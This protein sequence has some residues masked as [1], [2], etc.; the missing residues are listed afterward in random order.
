MTT[1]IA[2]FNVLRHPFQLIERAIPLVMTPLALQTMGISAIALSKRLHKGVVTNIRPYILQIVENATSA[3]SLTLSQ[4]PFYLTL[5]KV[6]LAAATVL[7]M[8][9]AAATLSS[10]GFL[11]AAVKEAFSLYSNCSMHNRLKAALAASSDEERVRQGLAI[12]EEVLQQQPRGTGEEDDIVR[13]IRAEDQKASMIEHFEAEGYRFLK[14][15]YQADNV[16]QK[17]SLLRQAE[18]F[19]HLQKVIHLVEMAAALLALIATV[20]DFVAFPLT[21]GVPL[22][23]LLA[24]CGWGFSFVYAT[25]LEKRANFALTEC[26]IYHVQNTHRALC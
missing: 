16:A 18:R 7:A 1:A 13:A 24:L 21:A 4:I 17:L 9:L 10:A 25:L 19:M 23:W 8:N 11:W 20:L 14:H 2:S 12:Y 26:G 15:A 22:F 6:E 5:V 3:V